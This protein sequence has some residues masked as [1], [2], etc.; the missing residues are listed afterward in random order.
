MRFQKCI[1]YKKMQ[2]LLHFLSPELTTINGFVPVFSCF[3]FK[4]K[5]I[6]ICIYDKH[7][8]FTKDNYSFYSFICIFSLSL[9]CL[10]VS[11]FLMIL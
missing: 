7:V 9:L 2:P 4:Y 11:F 5:N 3:Y 8:T 1:K 10:R 6:Y